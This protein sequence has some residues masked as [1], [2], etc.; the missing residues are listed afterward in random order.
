M[1]HQKYLRKSFD[2][3]NRHGHGVLVYLKTP[4]E[5]AR[6]L[7]R[8]RN[9]KNLKMLSL[10]H[11]MGMDS[12][13]YGIGAQI[14]RSLGVKKMILLTSFPVKRAGI[15]G[16]GLDIIETRSL[17]HISKESSDKSSIV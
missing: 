16:Y 10:T 5:P 4:S 9:P 2:Q 12:K 7:N 13:D 11:K 6:S 17:H 3:I 15:K 14:L 1:G 8:V